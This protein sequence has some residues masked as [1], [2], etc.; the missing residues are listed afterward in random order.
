MTNAVSR[1]G[2]KKRCSHKI[3]LNVVPRGIKG[4]VSKVDA[5]SRSRPFPAPRMFVYG[6]NR[7]GGFQT[8]WLMSQRKLLQIFILSLP[9]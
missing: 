4:H 5:Q 7:A 6:V 8:S 2:W 9:L 1:L 3:Y